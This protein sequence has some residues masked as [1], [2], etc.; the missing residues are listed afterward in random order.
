MY[1]RPL[2][3]ISLTG[4]YVYA[5]HACVSL[6][7][8]FPCLPAREQVHVQRAVL[9][10]M[11]EVLIMATGGGNPSRVCFCWLAAGTCAACG[12]WVMGEE[13]GTWVDSD[14]SGLGERGDGSPGKK[15]VRISMYLF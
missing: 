1:T 11:W 4:L 5:V 2:C 15:T 3:C 6:G 7:V 12:W 8:H 9:V 10:R 13:D 14:I